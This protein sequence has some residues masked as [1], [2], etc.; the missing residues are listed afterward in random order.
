MD[1]AVLADHRVKLKE[2]EKK[3][4]YLKLARELK[5]LGNI[6]VIFISIVTGALGRVIEGFSKGL[7]DLEI[8]GRVE[9]IQT[10]TLLR[11]TRILRK[12]LST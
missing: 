7:A 8:G 3:D 9:S 6:R 4:N 2:N 12:L 10:T 1:F 11:S 5:K